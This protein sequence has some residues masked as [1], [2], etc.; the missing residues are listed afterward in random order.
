MQFGN[1][2]QDRAHSGDLNESTVVVS[3]A[4]D[5]K[6]YLTVDMS[7]IEQR[8]LAHEN[9]KIHCEVCK[10]A[11]WVKPNGDCPTCGRLLTWFPGF[12][13]ETTQEKQK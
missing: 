8:L 12:H 3:K 4:R 2:S 13:M 6:Q 1:R 10:V 11:T 5:G 7:R 9:T